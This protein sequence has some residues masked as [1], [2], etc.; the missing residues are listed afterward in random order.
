[1]KYKEPKMEIVVFETEDVIATSIL[2]DGGNSDG[3]IMDV[4]DMFGN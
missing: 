2:T 4:S 3:G 1:M